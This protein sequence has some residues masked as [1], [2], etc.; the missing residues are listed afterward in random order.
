MAT[1]DFF[2]LFGKWFKHIPGSMPKAKSFWKFSALYSNSGHMGELNWNDQFYIKSK[3][4][5][6]WSIANNW[7]EC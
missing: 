1:P 5:W 6:I 4:S 7:F 2:F 3:A